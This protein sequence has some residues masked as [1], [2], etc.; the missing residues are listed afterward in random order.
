MQVQLLLRQVA[1]C[2]VQ[3]TP[4]WRNSNTKKT[5]T[6][7]TDE[8]TAVVDFDN[9]TFSNVTVTAAGANLQLD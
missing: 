8:T 1:K 6:P 9:L 5:G 7:T 4:R 3:T 2:Q